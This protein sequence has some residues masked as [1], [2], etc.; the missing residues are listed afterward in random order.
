MYQHVNTITRKTNKPIWYERD[1]YDIGCSAITHVKKYTKDKY[2]KKIPWPKG[3][4]NDIGRSS[5]PNRN[6]NLFLGAVW[7]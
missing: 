5:I 1:Y 7:A 6:F 3:H 2:N 4:Q